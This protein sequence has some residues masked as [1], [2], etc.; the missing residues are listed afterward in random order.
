MLKK[1]ANNPGPRPSTL[2]ELSGKAP[3]RPG[4]TLMEIVVAVGAVAIV[5]VGLA[6]IFDSVGKT[7]TGGRRLSVLNSYSS[8]IESQ[9]RRDFEAMTRDGF[10]VIRQQWTDGTN[11]G[12][13]NGKIDPPENS[14][15]DKVPLTP[16]QP[17][18]D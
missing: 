8:L 1:L 15:S 10:L 9:F 6:S 12:V 4:F 11:D 14:D 3:A 17:L 13:P 16:D 5:A 18:S 7:V 2:G